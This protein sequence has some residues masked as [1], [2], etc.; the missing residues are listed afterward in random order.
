MKKFPGLKKLAINHSQRKE[1][2]DLDAPSL[3][4]ELDGDLQVNRGTLCQKS[5]P[6]LYPHTLFDHQETVFQL[7]IYILERMLHTT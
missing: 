1:E 4:K 2:K 7:L 5:S 3:F 6:F